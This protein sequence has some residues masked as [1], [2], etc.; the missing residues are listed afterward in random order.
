M[1]EPQNFTQNGVQ[2]NN[3]QNPSGIMTAD[4]PI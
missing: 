1:N 4:F 2:L 3:L